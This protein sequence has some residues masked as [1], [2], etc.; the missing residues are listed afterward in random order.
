MLSGG[1][2]AVEYCSNELSGDVVNV[3]CNI[4]W[5]GDK[6]GDGDRGIERVRIRGGKIEIF[7]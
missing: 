6:E 1:D 2:S 5:G 4:G 7:G 3:D